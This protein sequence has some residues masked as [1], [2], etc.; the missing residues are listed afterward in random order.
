MEVVLEAFDSAANC[1]RPDG[2]NSGSCSIVPKQRP[3]T[4]PR[5]RSSFSPSHSAA[6][7]RRRP[8]SSPIYWR[9]RRAFCGGRRAKQSRSPLPGAS[10]LWYCRVDP[11][12]LEA[13]ILNLVVNARDAMPQGGKLCV[14]S[15]NVSV[16]AASS[17]FG[18]ASLLATMCVSK[19]PT[20]A[21]AWNP[22]LSTRAALGDK[23][24]LA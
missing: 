8:S 4:P 11:V 14:E 1:R 21:K 18:R 10:D 15:A 13:A 2:R 17:E 16:G 22:R 20:P 6:P 19:C 3:S 24:V 12:Q 23:V 7:S 9:S 5:S